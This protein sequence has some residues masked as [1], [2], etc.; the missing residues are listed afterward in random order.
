MEFYTNMIMTFTGDT[1]LSLS[2][3]VVQ[4]AFDKINRLLRKIRRIK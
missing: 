2:D 4:T 3:S 1:N